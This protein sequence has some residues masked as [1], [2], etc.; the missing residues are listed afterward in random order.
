MIREIRLYGDAVL[1]RTAKPI[2]DISEE[3]VRLA[4]DMTE[5]MF[6]RRGIGLAAPQVGESTSLAVVDL[7][8]GDEKG[9]TLVLINPEVVGQEGEWTYEEG[10]LSIPEVRADVVRPKKVAVRFLDIDGNP[11]ELEAEDLLARV[12]LHEV[13][14]LKGV[15]F[16]DRL[17][18]LKRQ[19]LRPKLLKIAKG[20]IPSKR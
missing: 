9:R 11:H 20:E 15:L 13:D 1:R 14:H 3:V 8:L 17:P 12:I 7:S 5:T 6:A 2:S 16:V 19:I 4:E 10:C 18:P